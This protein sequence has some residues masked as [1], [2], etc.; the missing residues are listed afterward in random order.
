MSVDRAIK[1]GA[2]NPVLTATLYDGTTAIDLSGLASATSIQLDLVSADGNTTAV[3]LGA[4]GWGTTNSG[5]DGIVTYTWSTGDT[6]STGVY[7]A[8]FKVTWSDDTIT[9]FPDSGFE[10]VYVTARASTG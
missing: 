10:Q 2:T 5:S 4:C 9:W 3:S 1:R 6:D 8:E 7:N